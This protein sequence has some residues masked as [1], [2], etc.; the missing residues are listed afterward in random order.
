MRGLQ[1][2]LFIL[3]TSAA[4]GLVSYEVVSKSDAWLG[5]PL[6]GWHEAQKVERWT[7]FVAWTGSLPVD[8]VLHEGQEAAAY[9]AYF[10]RRGPR[11]AVPVSR[12]PRMSK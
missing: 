10:L 9:Y 11:S 6:P 8:R 3:A 1:K 4:T 7:P 12:S 5:D 2:M